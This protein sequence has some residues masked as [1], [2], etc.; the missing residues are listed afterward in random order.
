VPTWYVS[1]LTRR[2]VTVALSGDGGDEAFGGYQR[3]L[4]DRLIAGYLLLPR[5]LREGVLRRAI[6]A[7]PGP[8][9]RRGLV[10]RLERFVA[11]ADPRR[12]RQYVRYSARSR[13]RPVI[14]LASPRGGAEDSVRCRGLYGGRTRRLSRPDAVGYRTPTSRRHLEGRHRGWARPRRAPSPDHRPRVRGGLLRRAESCAATGKYRKAGTH[15]PPGLTGANGLRMPVA[16][17]FAGVGRDGRDLLLRGEGAGRGYFA[18][19]AVERSP[20]TG[21]ADNGRPALGAVSSALVPG[22]CRRQLTFSQNI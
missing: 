1:E 8:K 17:W 13:T 15:L 11:T 9:R 2:S 14:A 22:V 20:S 3:Y 6:D 21:R 10:G 16:E 4:A 12:E 5:A 7:L 19:E 18:A